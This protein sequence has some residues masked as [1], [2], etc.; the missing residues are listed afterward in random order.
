LRSAHD[1]P[2]IVYG[3]TNPQQMT[4]TDAGP[5]LFYQG[6]GL[7]D[8]RISGG[9]EGAPSGGPV[10]CEFQGDA[11]LV[12]NAVP[13]AAAVGKVAGA[14]A[15]ASGAFFTLAAPSAGWSFPTLIVGIPV[16][17]AGG[18]V[19]AGVQALDLGFALG[20]T[21]VGSSV[22]TITGPGVA[23]AVA[24]NY[25]RV[26]MKLAIPG[27]GPGFTTLY[28]SV[29]ATP[30]NAGPT[31]A[32]SAAG[33]I[34]MSTPAGSALASTPIA[35]ADSTLGI[36][37]YPFRFTGSGAFLDPAQAVTRVLAVTAT[38]ATTGSVV[39]RGF[40]IY[41]QPMSESITIT[42]TGTATGKKAWKYIASVQAVGLGGT[43]GNLSVD[44][45]NGLGIHI[46]ADFVEYLFTYQAGAVFTPTLIAPDLTSPATPTTGDVRGT[47]VPSTAPNGANRYVFT[48]TPDLSQII[49][50]T[51][52]D[53]RSLYG[54]LQA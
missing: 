23:N 34:L 18:I 9:A 22:L 5:S 50:A 48:Y 14:Q 54:V 36:S 51:N 37:T 19:P 30:I 17:T 29:V 35:T 39:I 43:L 3:N 52:L 6:F 12:L 44:T 31:S 46:R 10:V 20:T 13:Q 49:G 16:Y 26:G 42:P 33:T 28:P 53:A 11:L 7:I 1:G 38:A 41:H 47:V 32:V 21:T 24:Q 2:I 15:V 45:T 40:D 4:N 27:S 8:A 25:F